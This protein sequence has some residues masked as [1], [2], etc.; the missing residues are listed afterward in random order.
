MT[1]PF[2]AVVQTMINLGFYN[3]IFP[4]IITAAILYA[5]LRKSKVLGESV[6]INAVLALSVAFMIFGYP[7][8][9]GVSL[10]TP[11]ATF[12]T[13]ATVFIIIVFVGFMLASL[14]YPNLGTFLTERIK[15]RSI[16]FLM[17]VLAIALF[18]TSGLITVFVGNLG[19]PAAPGSAPTT[20]TDV[21]L[22]AAGL[23]I[24]IVL[25]IV[26]TGIARI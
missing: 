16:L 24:F 12:F 9:V 15:S 1:T 20:P 2:D 8:I 5:L 11:L 18:V 10:A 3:F 14:F 19:K 21:I 23:I 17:V 4:F 6:V 7:V 22:I 13:Q 26:A 25:L